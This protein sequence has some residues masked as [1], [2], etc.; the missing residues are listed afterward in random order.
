MDFHV[1]RTSGGDV[2]ITIKQESNNYRL[3]RSFIKNTVAQTND[4]SLKFLLSKLD[5]LMQQPP[6]LTD[7]AAQEPRNDERFSEKLNNLGTK[8]DLLFKAVGSISL[9]DQKSVAVNFDK[10][11]LDGFAQRIET[12]LRAVI[13]DKMVGMTMD[14]QTLAHLRL[15]TD[16]L[17]KKI[18]AVQMFPASATITHAPQTVTYANPEQNS[19]VVDVPDQAPVSTASEMPQPVKNDGDV[20]RYP[21]VK[22]RTQPKCFGHRLPR[23]TPGVNPCLSCAYVNDCQMATENKVRQ[24]AADHPPCFGEHHHDLGCGT[25]DFN[26]KCLEA[27]EK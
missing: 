18:E 7:A 27:S 26:H 25:C 14:K 6:L 4:A 19:G 1:H 17:L 23:E 8:L 20:L 11:V 24:V 5:E 13:K 21:A 15:A 9:P 22:K 12:N 3:L 2:V 16:E 10:E